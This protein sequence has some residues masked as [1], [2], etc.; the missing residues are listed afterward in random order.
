MEINVSISKVDVVKFDG[1]SNFGLWQRR[2]KDLL[3]QQGLVKALYGRAKK[4]ET[5]TNNEWEELNMKAMSTIQLCLADELMY[6]VMDD[7]STMLVRLKLESWYMSK[8]LTN[9]L[10]LKRKLYE[11]KMAKGADLAQHVHTFNKIISDLLRIDIKFND[12]NKAMMLLSSLPASYEHL[13]MTLFWGKE[14][15]EFEEISR[16]LLD[17]Y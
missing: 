10:N 16:A 6:D 4:L 12:E 11:L 8:S 17:H 15:M 13:V 1:T 5:M 3:V 2:V 14:T 7:V 9:K